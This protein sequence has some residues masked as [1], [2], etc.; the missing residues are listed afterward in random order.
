MLMGLM[1][2]KAGDVMGLSLGILI[3]MVI[4][5]VLLI[6]FILEKAV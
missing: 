6:I 3:T 2:S 4:I 5:I 1:N